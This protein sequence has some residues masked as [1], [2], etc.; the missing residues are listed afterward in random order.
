MRAP[1]A[2][3]ITT[4][5]VGRN[6]PCP[7]GSGRKY[8]HCCQAKDPRADMPAGTAQGSSSALRQR[9]QALMLAAKVHYEA[10][11]WA[12][13][14]PLLRE[15]VRFDP[16]N[17][18]AHR[19]LGLACQAGA[20]TAEAVASLQ[21]AVELQP[22]LESALIHLAAALLQQG[23][24]T[25]AL[26]VLRKL[27]RRAEDPLARRLYSARALAMEGKPDEAEKEF[28]RLI[29]LAPQMAEPRA[30]LGE[31]LSIRG[32]FEEA[33]EHLTLAIEE[34]PAAFKKL[35]VVK[36]F[37]QIDRPLLD[38]MRSLAEGPGLNAM[39]R[40][41]VQ[42]GLGKAFDDLG[43]YAEAM[44]QYEAA[45]RLRGTERP[46][47]AALVAKYNSIIEGYTGEA[48]G[49]ARQ[50]LARPACPGDDLPVL[51][52]GMPRSGTTLVEQILSSHPAVAAGGELPFWAQ[53][54]R[55]WQT[56]G[57]GS[58]EEGKLSRVAEDYRAELRRVG[59]KALRVT[60]KRPRNFEPLGL[61]HLALPDARI[62][63]CR[64][65]PVDTCLSIFF[66]NFAA[67]HEFA[68]D[69][70]DLAFFYRQYERL[71]EHWRRVLPADRFTEVQYETLVAYREAE[72]RRLIDFCGLDWDEAC[73]APERN[74]RTVNTASL[75][76]ARQPVYAT[77]VER[78]R[79]YEPWLGELR[80]L[81]P[82]A[83]AE[84][85]EAQAS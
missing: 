18:L 26:V 37:T 7:C 33:A 36:R 84:A 27:S 51:I 70:G 76:Q 11:R 38:R 64:R 40:A 2:A 6:D 28:R 22:S 60:D 42:F 50:L 44:R 82:A 5:E 72:T 46:D 25:E 65:N 34:I 66:A 17:A 39:A 10:Q 81:L 78:W 77:S 32:M 83:E 8:K 79:R 73:L 45:N 74:R 58:L 14:I 24:T 43:D 48:L 54:E 31:L 53:R 4:A 71:I 68:W 16:K 15:I 80:T 47:R 21:R 55:D 41:S 52:I 9:L 75:W 1:G 57:I 69:R 67:G 62:V 49:G 29:A 30:F 19:N 35:S 63:H 3:A 12:D 85:S 61:I 20:R 59:P 56:S 23:R 13:A